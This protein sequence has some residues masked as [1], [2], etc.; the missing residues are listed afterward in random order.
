M[1]VLTRLPRAWFR[2]TCSRII[3]FTAT[4]KNSYMFIREN[5]TRSLIAFCFDEYYSVVRFRD[6]DKYAISFVAA[7]RQGLSKRAPDL[8]ESWVPNNLVFKRMQR[9]ARRYQSSPWQW[10]WEPNQYYG[11][12]VTQE[13]ACDG[14]YQQ[15]QLFT[16]VIVSDLGQDDPIW[17][18]ARSC[19]FRL[20]QGR[21]E[22][23]LTRLCVH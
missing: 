21:R 19:L 2:L 9:R 5:E 14:H 11:R 20:N 22:M 3:N 4:E 6:H 18:D 12:N 8:N 10:W 7:L 15:A 23:V 17:K 1:S 16:T 13:P